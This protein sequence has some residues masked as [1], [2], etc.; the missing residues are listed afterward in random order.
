MPVSPMRMLT[1]PLLRSHFHLHFAVGAIELDGVVQEV[2]EN[3]FQP[4]FMAD[5]LQ[6]VQFF[7]EQTHALHPRGGFHGAQGGFSAAR[8]ETG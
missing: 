6:V 5:D 4:Q 3:L 7:A 2:D 8:M 1:L